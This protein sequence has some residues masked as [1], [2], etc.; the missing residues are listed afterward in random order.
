MAKSRSISGVSVGIKK[1]FDTFHQGSQLID[2][3]K[4]GTFTTKIAN[5]LEEREA[6]FRLSYQ[7]YLEKGFIEKNAHQWLVRNYD[8]INDTVILM[9]QDKE[10][11]IVGT[12]TL[13]FENS[14]QLPA[15]KIYEN[16][17]NFL[18]KNNYKITEISRLVIDPKFR[19]SKEILV[20]LFNYLY[21]YT[22]IVKAY[23]CLIIEVNPRH[24]KYY[25]LLLNFKRIGSKKPCPNVLNAPAILMCSDLKRE[26]ETLRLHHDSQ[27]I[28]N[29]SLYSYFLK[30][31][32]EELVA[33]Y[34]KKQTKPI[35][36]EEKIYFGFTVSG[37]QEA[38]TI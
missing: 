31:D 12:V 37:V 10:K 32:Q 30:P 16:E 23:N 8:F 25:E 7:V 15:E 19:N 11:N 24:I 36:E 13:V 14:T 4:P 34:L 5:T 35:S 2:K 21:I 28:N 17:L 6:V 20:Q 27:L 3:L 38:V 18:R 1:T 33:A 29:R 22:Y 26:I 9:V